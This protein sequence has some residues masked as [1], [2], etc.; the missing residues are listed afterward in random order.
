MGRAA[1]GLGSG[2]GGES[3]DGRAGVL[4]DER[5]DEPTDEST[6]VRAAA[7]GDEL[8]GRVTA[9]PR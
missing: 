3:E 1:A 4:A 7:R 2:R 8:A 9:A 5:G 6:D